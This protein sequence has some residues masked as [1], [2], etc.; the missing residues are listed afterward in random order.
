MVTSFSNR[1]GCPDSGDGPT[2][3]GIIY[4]SSFFSRQTFSSVGLIAV[5]CSST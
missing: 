1:I 5:I 2:T 3:L 4:L